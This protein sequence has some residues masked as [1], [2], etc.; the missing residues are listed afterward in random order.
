MKQ[1][2]TI[3]LVLCVLM[4]SAC[5]T[6]R[7]VSKSS[8]VP[9]TPVIT[10]AVVGVIDQ[11]NKNQPRFQ[12]AN[13]SK[14]TFAFEMG[15]R[16]VNVSASCKIKKDT[17]IYISVQPLLGIEMFKAE[18]TTDSMRVFDK[19][20]HRYY[21][22]DYGYFYSRFGV[23]VNFY[24]LQSL[25]TAQLFCIGKQGVIADSCKLVP[26]GDGKNTIEYENSNM[27]Q[28]SLLSPLYVIQQVLLKAKNSNYQLETNYA[29]YT[30]VNGISFPQTIKLL[31]TNDRNRVACEFSILRVEFN[32]EIKLSP[33]NPDRF[34]RGDIDQLLKK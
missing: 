10:N 30:L 8:T 20:N 3:M 17:A 11:V 6:T 19:M 23:N 12:T 16:K 33:T 34:T 28:S 27:M 9:G 2:T 18:L 22:V 24:S 7:T 21:V 1:K 4:F 25:L 13:I 26:A 32:K 31:A 29:D 5:K 15:E 14:M